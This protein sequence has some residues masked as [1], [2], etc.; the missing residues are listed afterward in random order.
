MPKDLSMKKNS[1]LMYQIG[2]VINIIVLVISVLVLASGVLFMIFATEISQGLKDLFRD[3]V[4]PKVV[5]LWGL[6]SVI[7]HLFVL[8]LSIVLLVLSNKAIKGLEAD[9]T[10]TSPHV[11]MIIFGVFSISALYGIFYIIG[12]VFGLVENNNIQQERARAQQAVQE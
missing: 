2:R 6:G 3:I 4:D 1:S 11:L 9:D 8:V 5:G 10:N 12:G 7:I